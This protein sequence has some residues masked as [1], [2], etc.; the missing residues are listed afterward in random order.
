M[1]SSF[2]CFNILS[3]SKFSKD[4]ELIKEC[5]NPTTAQATEFKLYKRAKH[6]YSESNR[7]LEYKEICES[8]VENKPEA[9]D[10]CVFF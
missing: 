1:L 7:V 2:Q 9:R 5:L 10:F 8:N 4:E 3:F 6:V